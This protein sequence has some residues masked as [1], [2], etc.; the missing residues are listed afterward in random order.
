[1]LTRNLARTIMAVLQR[2]SR[3][4]P[5]ADRSWYHTECIAAYLQRCGVA[6]NVN[7]TRREMVLEEHMTLPLYLYRELQPDTALERQDHLPEEPDTLLVR[8]TDLASIPYRYC[9]GEAPVPDTPAR[10]H[11]ING[12]AQVHT[13]LGAWR[14]FWR[15]LLL[16]TPSPKEVDRTRRATRQQSS[17]LRVCDCLSSAA[18][19]PYHS[20]GQSPRNGDA[21]GSALRWP[22]LR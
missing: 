3:L 1:M 13:V 15:L 4:G 14:A 6:V 16:L 9:F 21:G 7:Y 5:A 8:A 11:R 10:C 17:S 18:L 2:P 22:P 19:Q 20:V 12:L